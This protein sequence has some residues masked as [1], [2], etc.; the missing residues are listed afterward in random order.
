MP[1]DTNNQ[2]KPAA[3]VPQPVGQN[4]NPPLPNENPVVPASPQVVPDIS[5]DLPPMPEMDTPDENTGE[6]EIGD[7]KN[8]VGADKIDLPP[9]ITATPK[10]T[11]RG[12]RVIA[13]ILGL[14]LLVGGISAGVTLVRQQQDIREKA[15]FITEGGGGG[16]TST[17]KT[18]IGDTTAGVTKT[19]IG[20]TTAGVA[21]TT[22]KV[23]D[24]DTDS[25][26]KTGIGDTTAGV[27]KTGIGDT[28]ASVT[29]TGTETV[30]CTDAQK[31]VCANRGELCS[32]PSGI[33][34]PKGDSGTVGCTDAQKAVCANRGELCSAPSGICL[35][36]G[37]SGAKSPGGN[38]T[39]SSGSCQKICIKTD[40]DKVPAGCPNPINNECETDADCG[41]GDGSTTTTTTGGSTSAQCLNIKAFDTNWNALST[42]ELGQLQVGDKVRFTVAG[43]TTSGTID[44]ARF[45][46]NGVTRAAVTAKRPGTNEYFDEYTI[47]AGTT[48]FSIRAQLNHSTAGWF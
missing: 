25:G 6:E 34:L 43:T 40:C 12:G 37:D 23:S 38:Q 46:I 13:T 3:P 20:D 32:A 18:G 42:T 17:T 4:Q 36:K 26:A 45:I 8:Q 35:P 10:K 16:P 28:T 31:A 19:G 14:L 29:K 1:D 27:T 33:C 11:R 7:K 22:G 48:S 2:N 41:G 21:K 15:R 47:P 5:G 39:A 30:G 44:R 24:G 9:V